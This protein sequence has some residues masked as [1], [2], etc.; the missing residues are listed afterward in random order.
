MNARRTRSLQYALIATLM[1]A[2]LIIP[3][4]VFAQDATAARERPADADCRGGDAWYACAHAHAR[5]NP[6]CHADIHGA[7]E[8]IGGSAANQL[9]HVQKILLAWP[10]SFSRRWPR[11][12][13]QRGGTG[14]AE[15]AP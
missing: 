15:A 2:A 14:R 5:A 6:D 3:A 12:T 1:L 11:W 13:G 8:P 9:L 10:A 7:S 4:T